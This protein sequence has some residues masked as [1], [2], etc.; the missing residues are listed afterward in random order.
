MELMLI[1]TTHL[2]RENIVKMQYI[3]CNEATFQL[4]RF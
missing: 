4:L 1:E 2:K 3:D